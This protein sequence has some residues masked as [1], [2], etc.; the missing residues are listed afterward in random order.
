MT[1]YKKTRRQRS[2]RGDDSG[3]TLV[4]VLAALAVFSVAALGIL[5]VS[6]ENV[7]AARRI[8]AKSLARIVAENRLTESLTQSTV[9][10]VGIRTGMEDLANRKWRWTQIVTETPNPL[11]LQ[12]TVSVSEVNPVDNAPG[13]DLR[14]DAE[15]W[16]YEANR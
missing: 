1:S 10:D 15:V 9:L 3:F 6:T 13:G 4:E 8:E 5:N 11:L 14:V 12:V 16:A 7:N 2:K